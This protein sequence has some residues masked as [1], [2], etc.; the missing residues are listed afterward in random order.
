MI[1]NI[2]ALNNAANISYLS[3][4]MKSNPLNQNDDLSLSVLMANTTGLNT[5]SGGFS[6]GTATGMTAI[7]AASLLAAGAQHQAITSFND[8]GQWIMGK[9]NRIAYPLSGTGSSYFND[10]STVNMID[11]ISGHISA[12]EAGGIGNSNYLDDAKGVPLAE[13]ATIMNVA[14]FAD[15]SMD[16]GDCGMAA[17]CGGV[18]DGG[19]GDCG[20]GD[21]ALAI[22]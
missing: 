22:F 7:G 8:N 14:D 11:P 5:Y 13:I 20:G 12:F 21:W 15:C 18:A 6:P 1:S 4:K 2:I 16:F 17:D 19:G 10:D 3:D 9:S